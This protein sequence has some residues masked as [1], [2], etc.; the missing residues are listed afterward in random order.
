MQKMH[1]REPEEEGEDKE[2]HED[3]KEF[4]RWQ[5]TP[6]DRKET[7]RNSLEG[8]RYP[9]VYMRGA[10][11]PFT[12]PAD[13][14]T[15]IG[16]ER[17]IQQTP[18]PS[19]PPLQGSWT[20]PTGGTPPYQ[21]QTRA[22]FGQNAQGQGWPNPPSYDQVQNRRATVQGP[23][24]TPTGGQKGATVPASGATTTTPNT[25][26]SLP[27]ARTSTAGGQTP[28]ERQT[29]PVPRATVANTPGRNTGATTLPRPVLG[30]GFYQ[31]PPTSQTAMAGTGVI[32]GQEQGD[33]WRHNN[34]DPNQMAPGIT[35][36]PA[37]P[38]NDGYQ[39]MPYMQPEAPQY[40][41]GSRRDTVRLSE[42]PKYDGRLGSNF[43]RFQLQLESRLRLYNVDESRWINHLIA[44]CEGEAFDYITSLAKQGTLT[45]GQAITCLNERYRPGFIEKQSLF[46]MRQLPS[47]TAEDFG[48]RVRENPAF[49]NATDDVK[50]QVFLNGIKPVLRDRII[51]SK[52]RVLHEAIS[53]AQMA[54]SLLDPPGA[55]RSAV[56]VGTQTTRPGGE[57]DDYE[58]DQAIGRMQQRDN[59][60]TPRDNRRN[61]RQNQGERPRQT[62]QQNNRNYNKPALRRQNAFRAPRQ[63][64]IQPRNGGR[65]RTACWNCG[66]EGHYVRD[67]PNKRESVQVGICLRCGNPPGIR[68]V[69]GGVS[70][71]SKCWGVP[72]KAASAN[73]RR[74]GGPKNRL[75]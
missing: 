32:N 33:V 67:C 46:S 35:P 74:G 54:E 59:S 66:V 42:L 7:A 62:N 24:Q 64:D 26:W 48:K 47:E 38:H 50:L 43:E 30:N 69:P 72:I 12:S 14:S 75:N 3:L 34:V 52:P 36:A 19:A 21:Y 11:T 58:M 27:R 22:L 23:A 4:A 17:T 51:F 13:T 18:T 60:D 9:D 61:Q 71:C 41:R 31:S 8:E 2:L 57:L 63:D 10:P 1:M 44:S 20:T 49:N 16:G 55:G 53:S 37:M 39:Q 5:L 6:P 73:G 65:S 45:Y 40:E 29:G 68:R 25:T 56:S 15:P 28:G 70:L